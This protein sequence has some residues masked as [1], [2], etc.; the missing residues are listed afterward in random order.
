MLL[1]KKQTLDDH[2]LPFTSMCTRFSHDAFF[3]LS[4]Q[5]GVQLC[6]DSFANQATPLN[7]LLKFTLPSVE[8]DE[9]SAGLSNDELLDALQVSKNKKLEFLLQQFSTIEH[10]PLLKN[11]LW[12]SLKAFVTIRATKLSYSRSFN[13]LPHKSIYFQ[14]SILKNFD[15][16]A[17][18]DSPLPKPESCDKNQLEIVSAVIRKSMLLTMRETDPATYINVKTIRLYSLERGISVAIYGMDAERLL[19]LQ[20]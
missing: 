8:R 3:W 18:I 1:S 20:S 17:L 19:P 11:Y 14:S 15:Y 5:H 16:R 4:Q 12:D 9:T 7:E 13:K 6:F 2:G 10:K